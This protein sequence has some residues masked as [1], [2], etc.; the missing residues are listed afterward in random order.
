MSEFEKEELKNRIKGMSEEELF[1]VS[2]LIPTDMLWNEL[3]RR[4]ETQR[5]MIFEI[6]NTLHEK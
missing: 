1:I 4:E 2:K 3:R 6:K 5:Q